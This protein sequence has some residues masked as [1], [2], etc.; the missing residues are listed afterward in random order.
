MIWHLSV[1]K[2]II[3]MCILNECNV[4]VRVGLNWLIRGLNGGL[5]LTGK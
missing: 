1:G 2:R 3:L 5:M 4:R